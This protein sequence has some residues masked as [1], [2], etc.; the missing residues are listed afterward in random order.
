VA[1]EAAR[2]RR[3]GAAS[4]TGRLDE[5]GALRPGLTLDV[6][7]GIYYA[8]ASPELFLLLTRDQ[9]WT[10]TGYEEWL[11]DPLVYALLGRSPADPASADPASAGPEGDR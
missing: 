2:Q 1:A 6:A 7:G 9:G 4:I 3:F 10:V 11:A 8:I 5:L